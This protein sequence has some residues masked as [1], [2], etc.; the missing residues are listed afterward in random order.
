[1]Q[2]SKIGIWKGTLGK[3]NANKE[4]ALIVVFLHLYDPDDHGKLL[5]FSVFL[6]NPNIC[7]ADAAH[8]RESHEAAGN[9]L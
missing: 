2:I 1:M 7:D 4:C 5:N 3:T 8:A 9:P 6:N